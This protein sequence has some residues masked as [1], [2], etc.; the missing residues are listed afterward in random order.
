MNLMIEINDGV[1]PVI[2]TTA[3]DDAHGSIPVK[4]PTVTGFSI[5]E[6]SNFPWS[7]PQSSE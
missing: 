2:I 1:I 7:W 5:V 6:S 3:R 4:S